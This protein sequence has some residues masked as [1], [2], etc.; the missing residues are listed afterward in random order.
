MRDASQSLPVTDPDNGESG[1]SSSAAD[2]I[3]SHPDLDNAPCAGRGGHQVTFFSF[4]RDHDL[5]RHLRLGRSS[6]R[7]LEQS[8]RPPPIRVSV[9]DRLAAVLD[10]S[11]AMAR[12]LGP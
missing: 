6:S 7:R 5:K 9:R 4:G 12:V 2:A 11:I 1:A 10:A 3:P 8:Y